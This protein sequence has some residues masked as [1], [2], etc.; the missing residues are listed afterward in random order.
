VGTELTSTGLTTAVFN[1]KPRAPVVLLLEPSPPEVGPTL[2]VLSLCMS[3]VLSALPKT[4]FVHCAIA[5]L[6]LRLLG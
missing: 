6:L 3:M 1:F 5:S 2:L 4:L